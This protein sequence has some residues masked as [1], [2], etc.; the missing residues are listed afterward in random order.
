MGVYVYNAVATALNNGFSKS[1]VN[2]M[3]E[4]I[5]VIPYTEEEQ[6]ARAIKEQKK[7][8]AYFDRLAKNFE[9]KE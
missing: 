9:N 7:A 2:Y 5:R 3:E 8:I 6:K 1:K 4:P